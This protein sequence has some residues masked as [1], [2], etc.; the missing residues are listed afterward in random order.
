MSKRLNKCERWDDNARMDRYRDQ[1]EAIAADLRAMEA[2]EDREVWEMI[3]WIAVG[4]M[5]AIVILRVV[6]G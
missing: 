1:A 4:G 2:A 3:R 5:V 6:L